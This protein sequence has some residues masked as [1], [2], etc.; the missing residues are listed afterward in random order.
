MMDAFWSFDISIKGYDYPPGK[1]L[2]A[3]KKMLRVVKSGKSKNIAD[4]QLKE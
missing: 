4:C 1:V 2:G 3:G